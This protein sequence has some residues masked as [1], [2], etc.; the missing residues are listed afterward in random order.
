ML[1]VLL[2]FPGLFLLSHTQISYNLGTGVTHEHPISM[3]QFW[4]QQLFLI[5]LTADVPGKPRDDDPGSWA[6]V[7]KTGNTDG[8]LSS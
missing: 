5:Q 3:N 6:P 7:T 1:Q 8:S 4:S 2:L